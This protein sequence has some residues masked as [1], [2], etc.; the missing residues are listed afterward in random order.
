M[1]VNRALGSVT[2]QQ[3]YIPRIRYTEM[4]LAYAEAANEAWGPKGDYY[5][6]STDLYNCVEF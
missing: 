5:F 4:Y 2:N 1:D 3:H 6:Y